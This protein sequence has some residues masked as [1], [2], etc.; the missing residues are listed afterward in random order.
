MA[1]VTWGCLYAAGRCE[2]VIGVDACDMREDG[3]RWGRRRRIPLPR[4]F[5]WSI[6]R[7]QKKKIRRWLMSETKK[8]KSINGRAWSSPNAP[9]SRCPLLLG[10]RPPSSQLHTFVSV[11]TQWPR[12]VTPASAASFL[13]SFACCGLHPNRRAVCLTTPHHAALNRHRHH[14]CPWSHR[15]PLAHDAGSSRRR[16]GRERERGLRWVKYEFLGKKNKWM[17]RDREGDKLDRETCVC[18]ALALSSRRKKKYDPTALNYAVDYCIM[19]ISI[20]SYIN[21]MHMGCKR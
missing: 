3:L 8:K 20:K 21:M 13:S 11:E 18:P 6:A 12:C 10:H 7:T 19:L 15:S 4:L 16:R 5:C 9:R 17:E 1:P 2:V 14:C